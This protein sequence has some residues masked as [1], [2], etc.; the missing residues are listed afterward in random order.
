MV[1]ADLAEPPSFGEQFDAVVMLTVS[2][3]HEEPRSNRYHYATR[4]A[5][6]APVVFV[7]VD[8][9]TMGFSF[10]E[11]GIR[12]FPSC[13]SPTGSTVSRRRRSRTR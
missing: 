6:I 2:D 13:T 11:S 1:L 5:R 8:R 4:F 9:P 3:W 10:E 12:G 7:Q